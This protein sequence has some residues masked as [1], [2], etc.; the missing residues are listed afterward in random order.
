[1]APIAEDA[2][3]KGCSKWIRQENSI[4]PFGINLSVPDYQV[5]MP[6][7][8]EGM[9]SPGQDAPVFPWSW[10]TVSET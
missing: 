3:K 10:P 4:A 6:I 7:P 8:K 5:A 1:V 9:E 2:S